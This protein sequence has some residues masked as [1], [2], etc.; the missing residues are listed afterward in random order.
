M[1]SRSRWECQ[2]ALVPPP[3]SKKTHWFEE[4]KIIKLPYRR[5]YIFEVLGITA[6]WGGN[7]KTYNDCVHLTSNKSIL[8]KLTVTMRVDSA[9][10]TRTNTSAS[11]QCLSI[12]R[13]RSG[14]T[15][16]P[17]LKGRQ[18]SLLFTFLLELEKPVMFLSMAYKIFLVLK[19][20]E[21]HSKWSDDINQLL[22][23]K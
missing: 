2:G 22:L 1:Q 3:T 11:R 17:G 13:S 19:D 23:L 15:S 20:G 18:S 16:I 4:H 5:I 9:L 10:A 6:S 12:Q 14:L 8:F 21:R 7:T